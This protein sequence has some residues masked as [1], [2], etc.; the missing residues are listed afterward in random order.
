MLA[1]DTSGLAFCSTDLGQNFGNNVGNDFGVPMIRIVPH[2]P[3]F[4]Y[5]IVRMF[6]LMIYSVLVE[7]NIVFRHKSSLATMLSLYLKAKGGRH[8]NNW[9][10][11]ELA[12]I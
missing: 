3:E 8:Y 1:N 6:S 4:A 5:N 10:V 9:T 2:E 12:D 7:Y 11:H